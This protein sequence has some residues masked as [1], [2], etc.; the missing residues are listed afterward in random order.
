MRLG[1]MKI[2]ADVCSKYVCGCL[3]VLCVVLQVKGVSAMPVSFLLMF[4]FE[5]TM[6]HRDDGRRTL[7]RLVKS[8]YCFVRVMLVLACKLVTVCGADI[9][10][11]WMCGHRMD[12]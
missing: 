12:G 7:I 9:Y 3:C 4:W 6:D 5:E 2:Y 8:L 10:A 11:I 1:S